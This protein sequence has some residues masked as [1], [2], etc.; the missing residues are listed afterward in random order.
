MFGWQIKRGTMRNVLLTRRHAIKF[1][2][3]AS[4]RAFIE[5]LR[6]NLEELDL[7]RLHQSERMCPV[8]ARLPLGTAIVMPRVRPLTQLEFDG[9]DCIEFADLE[10]GFSLPIECKGDSFGVLNGKIVAVDYGGGWGG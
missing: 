4:Y 10:N 1:P 8:I 2:T 9:L 7:W 6:A 3:F 5:G